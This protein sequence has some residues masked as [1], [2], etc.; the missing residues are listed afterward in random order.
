M[1]RTLQHREHRSHTVLISTFQF[2]RSGRII[3]RPRKLHFSEAVTVLVRA[4][5]EFTRDELVLKERSKKLKLLN[6]AVFAGL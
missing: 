2:L 4:S 6:G 1:H 5:T 3:H